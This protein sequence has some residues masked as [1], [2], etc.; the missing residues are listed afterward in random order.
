MLQYS[1]VE[2]FLN[3]VAGLAVEVFKYSFSYTTTPV[4]ATIS[5]KVDLEGV[6]SC[7]NIMLS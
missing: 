5:A 2:S 7:L 3:K 1:Q 4:A 6:I